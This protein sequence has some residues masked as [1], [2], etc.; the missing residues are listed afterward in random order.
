MDFEA[1]EIERNID[2]QS[3][4]EY[5]IKKEEMILKA[6]MEIDQ[7]YDKKTKVINRTTAT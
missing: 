2:A 5:H 4:D 6:K 1:D 7:L 3:E